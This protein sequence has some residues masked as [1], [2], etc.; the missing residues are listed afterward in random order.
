MR[1]SCVIHCHCSLEVLNVKQSLLALITWQPFRIVGSLLGA[2]KFFTPDR[3][4]LIC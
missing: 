2:L 1:Q 4:S 3:G